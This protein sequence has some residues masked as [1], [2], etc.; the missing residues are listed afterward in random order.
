MPVPW[1]LWVITGDFGPTLHGLTTI[2]WSPG[3][4]GEFYVTPARYATMTGRG[5][6]LAMKLG[7]EDFPGNI[8][9]LI[10]ETN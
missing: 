1:M 9:D 6:D 4:F 5:K 10:K 8:A 2:F 7:C 3:V